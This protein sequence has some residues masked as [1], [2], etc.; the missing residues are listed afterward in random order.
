MKRL[1]FGVAI[2]AIVISPALAGGG[3]GDMSTE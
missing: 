3:H 1:L 2:V